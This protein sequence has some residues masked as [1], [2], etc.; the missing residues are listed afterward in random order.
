[1]EIDGQPTV[2][3][4]SEFQK[5]QM[6]GRVKPVAASEPPKPDQGSGTDEIMPQV[7]AKDKPAEPAQDKV[8]GE[9]GSSSN[10]EPQLPLIFQLVDLTKLVGYL[11]QSP[12][13]FVEQLE[14]QKSEDPYTGLI[15]SYLETVDY[16][17][18]TRALVSYQEH[19]ELGPYVRQLLSDEGTKWLSDVI[20]LIKQNANNNEPTV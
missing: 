20:T 3:T 16:G 6:E 14:A 13:A 5:L 2:V 17:S 4:E 12:A 10:D 9:L 8:L 7:T 19:R 1:M 18:L 15:W 11:E